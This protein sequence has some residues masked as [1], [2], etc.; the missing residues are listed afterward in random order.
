MIMECQFPGEIP[1]SVRNTELLN[2]GEIIKEFA[3]GG[4]S[5]K[6]YAQSN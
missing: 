1:A 3:M 6:K 4:T 5:G 2:G